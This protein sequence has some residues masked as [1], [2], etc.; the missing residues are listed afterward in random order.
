[1]EFR[2][3]T[4]FILIIIIMHIYTTGIIHHCNHSIIHIGETGYVH[5]EVGKVTLKSNGDEALSDEFLL[6]SNGNEALNDV[7]SI[8]SNGDEAFNAKKKL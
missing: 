1:M 3:S 2:L 5:A 6:K 4:T 7:F 8:K